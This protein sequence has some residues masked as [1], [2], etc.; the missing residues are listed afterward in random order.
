[1]T[2]TALALYSL[3]VADSVRC[4]FC[5]VGLRNWDPEDDPW[6]EHARWSPKCAYILEVKGQEFVQLV[7][8]AARQQ[9]VVYKLYIFALF[10]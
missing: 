7:L 9:Q 3:G 8:Q 2:I 10:E 1:M 6:V 4:F 5:A